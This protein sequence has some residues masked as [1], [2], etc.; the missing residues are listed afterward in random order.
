M[1]LLLQ[2]NLYATCVYCR[3]TCVLLEDPGELHI[4]NHKSYGLQKHWKQQ[5]WPYTGKH[6]EVTCGFLHAVSRPSGRGAGS[7]HRVPGTFLAVSP[8][9]ARAAPPFQL[10]HRLVLGDVS[11]S[12]VHTIPAEEKGGIS[13]Y[14]LLPAPRA[15]LTCTRMKR[16]Q[17]TQGSA[18]PLH[19]DPEETTG[20]FS[21]ALMPGAQPK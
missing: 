15:P 11:G 21:P 2:I 10:S 1:L 4:L 20:L 5:R 6:K 14:W 7:L 12:E 13:L 17:V 8:S 19:A 3:R 9:K 18:C 16:I